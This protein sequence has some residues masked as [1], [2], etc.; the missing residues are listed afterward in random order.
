MTA[1]HIFY[2]TSGSEVCRLVSAWMVEIGLGELA[3]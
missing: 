2:N 3:S 1:Q